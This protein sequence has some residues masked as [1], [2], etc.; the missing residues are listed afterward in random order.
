MAA[1]MQLLAASGPSRTPVG[2]GQA[3]GEAYGAGQ[4]GYTAAQQNLLQSMTMKQKMDEAKATKNMQANVSTFL[5][6][7]APEGVD[8]K[9]FKAQQ[10]MRLADVYAASNPDQASKFFDMA[11]KL[12][13]AA[14]KPVGEPFR[15]ADGKFYQ[16]TESGGVKLFG[17]GTVTPAEKPMGQPQQQLVDGKAQMVQYYDDGTFKVVS[18]IGQVAKPQGAPIM[19][20]K[21]GVPTMMQYF[22]DGTSKPLTGV[23]QFSPPSASITDVEFLT[24]EK[25]AGAGAPG[26]AKVQDYRKSAA[27]S[28]NVQVDT[29]QK[30]RVVPVNKDII[31]RLSAKTEQAETANQTLANIDR[32]LPALDKAIT[33]PAADYRTTLLRVGQFMGVAG[34]DANEILSNTQDVVQGLAMQ[35]L[36]AASYTKGQGTLTG[37]EREMLKRSAAGDQN[38][39]AAELRTAL[40]AAQKMADFRLTDQQKFLEKTLK[41]PGMEEY[42]EVYTIDRYQS[43]APTAAAGN[44]PPLSSIIKPKGAK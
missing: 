34:K 30:A 31:D 23:S 13:P 26:V 3:L 15:A 22:D 29:G 7:K 36:N 25:L 11:Q 18:G 17:G 21:D 43:V 10:Y 20:V 35:E 39:S 38:M 19:Q 8:A 2:L 6:Q 5:A 28:T 42:R 9:E 32:I 27:G 16:R 4:K 12:M 41:L 24:G 14:D 1:A 40:I 33:G 37:P 44:R